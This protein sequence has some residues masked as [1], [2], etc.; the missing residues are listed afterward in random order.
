MTLR[1]LPF[2]LILPVFLFSQL[3]ES[4]Q[5]NVPPNMVRIPAGYFSRDSGPSELTHQI[6]VASFYIDRFELSNRE[7]LKFV[8]A[9]DHDP[10]KFINDKRFNKPNHPVV[11]ISWYDA[12]AYAK[13]V[14]KRL[15]TEAEWEKAARGIDHRQW[16]W[17]NS[18]KPSLKFYYLNI[19]GKSD[20]FEFSSPVDYYKDGISPY[21]VFNMA[22]NVWEWCLD[23]YNENYYENTPEIDPKGLAKGERKVLK[24][25][26]WANKLES[27][28]ISGRIRNYPNAKL[29]MYGFRCVLDDLKPR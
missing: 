13:W 26:S 18:W 14:G 20:N 22:G 16:P 21:G 6:Y 17:G 10:P 27:T 9:T 29:E 25:G 19:F 8:K 11:G 2:Y 15:P 23:W 5:F 28:G 1:K 24:G 12:M 7:Y 3:A 4:Q